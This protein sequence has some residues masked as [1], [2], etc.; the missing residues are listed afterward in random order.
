MLQ[1]GHLDRA[2]SIPMETSVSP[3]SSHRPP[4]GRREGATRAGHSHAAHLRSLCPA[5]CAPAAPGLAVWGSPFARRPREQE[6]PRGLGQ[7]GTEKPPRSR[8]PWR[9][10]M[11]HQISDCAVT[12]TTVKS[13]LAPL[14]CGSASPPALRPPARRSARHCTSA[15]THGVFN[16]RSLGCFGPA[17]SSAHADW[18]LLPTPNRASSDPLLCQNC[19]DMGKTLVPQIQPPGKILGKRVT[20]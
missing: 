2:G 6:A 8:A 5:F 16:P 12:H 11:W 14:S 13:R 1:S 9:A 17:T 15:T 10:G 19:A 7:Q 18:H 3:L 20:A 4:V